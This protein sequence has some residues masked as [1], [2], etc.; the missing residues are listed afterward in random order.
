MS[1]FTVTI[2]G[3]GLIGTSLGLALKQH[4]D[5]PRLV[6]H[7]KELAR[8]RAAAKMGAFD[9]AEWNLINACEQADLIILAIPLS[10]IRPTLEAIADY[11]KP[12]VVIS[13]T[14]VSK[15]ST[16]AWA[17]E[18]LPAHAHFVGGNPIVHAPGLGYE[19]ASANLF[20]H[21]LYCLTP[22]SSADEKAVQFMVGILAMI[23]AEPFFLDAAEHDG[24][25]AAVDHLP[26]LLS[27]ALIQTLA[28]Q[29]SWRELRKMA[30][31][32]FARVSS[33]ADGDPDSLK[34]NFLQNRDTLAH[35]LD[36]YIQQLR[37]L[38]DLMMAE[39]DAGETLAQKLD[40]TIV[41]RLNWLKD[42]EKGNFTDPELISPAVEN[43]GFLG[44]MIGFG[45]FR[46][47][48]PGAAKDKKN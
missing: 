46:K 40:E 38:R 34:D 48:G 37:V 1:D 25:A 29:S 4:Q 43:P 15:V 20:K 31:G 35:W 24:L 12:G 17:K 3:T 16:L 32:L 33:G 22:A 19:Q 5:A 23:E 18:L 6:G 7:D 11:L 39:T 41:T 36:L 26:S 47:R 27:I 9:K 28:R 30:G 10:G 14:S 44:Q 42:Y 13:D 45:A 2:V 21:R 8:A